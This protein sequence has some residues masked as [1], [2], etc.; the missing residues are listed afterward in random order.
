MQTHANLQHLVHLI[1]RNTVQGEDEIAFD[2]ADILNVTRS[3]RAKYLKMPDRQILGPSD[4][5]SIYNT[6]NSKNMVIFLMITKY[7]FLISIIYL[8][9]KKVKIMAQWKIQI[10]IRQLVD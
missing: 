5:Q 4:I 3:Q 9:I 10:N 7:Y 2:Q 1:R 8:Y 6:E